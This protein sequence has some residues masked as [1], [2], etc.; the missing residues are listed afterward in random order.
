MTY[1]YWHIHR[2]LR[3][4]G[5][6]GETLPF[7]QPPTVIG[8][9]V[10]LPEPV[11]RTAVETARTLGM[12]D[13]FTGWKWERPLT[14]SAAAAV[15]PVLETIVE[16]VGRTRIVTHPPDLAKDRLPDVDAVIAAL[17]ALLDLLVLA[18][19]RDKAVENWAE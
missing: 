13:I 10:Y 15:I 16:Q 11:W 9:L 17:R 5:T 2:H 4:Q 8:N 1:D 14:V 3:L 18:R 7:G 19:E 6:S 12:A